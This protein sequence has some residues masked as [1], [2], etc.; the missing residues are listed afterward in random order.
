MV[1]LESGHKLLADLVLI[2]AGTRPELTLARALHIDIDK[3]VKV[4]DQMQ[5]S[6]PD[7]YA[8]GDL[9]EH[10]GKF[11]GI[12]PASMQQGRVAGAVMAGQAATYDGTV[13]ANVLKVVGIDLLS[14]GEIDTEDKFVCLVS[15]DEKKKIYRKL[16][17]KHFL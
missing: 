14:V 15:L 17:L 2:S 10:R 11:Y 12:W 13:P 3:G 16:V 1:I 7:I 8:A 4:N 5:T 9:I 6:Q